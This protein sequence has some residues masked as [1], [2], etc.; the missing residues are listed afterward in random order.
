MRPAITAITAARSAM[1]ASVSRRPA[2][3]YARP[4]PI[5]LVSKPSSF[6]ATSIP[7]RVKKTGQKAIKL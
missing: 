1:A 2:A 7:V 3:A 4:W 5:F 6:R